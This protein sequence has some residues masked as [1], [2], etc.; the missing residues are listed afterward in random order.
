MTNSINLPTQVIADWRDRW[1]TNRDFIDG[2]DAV[3]GKGLRYLPKNRC[4]DSEA[5]YQAHKKRTFF[6]PGASKI[7]QGI[8]GLIFRNSAQ[9]SAKSARVELLSQL[10]TPQGQSKD[11]FAEW[12][13][14]ETLIT[15]F[16]GLLVDHPDASQFTGLTA[17][18]ADA[19]GFRPFIA[20]YAAENI[21]EVTPGIINEKVLPVYVLLLED[22]G[23]T[24]RELVIREDGIYEVRIHRE[25]SNGQY[26]ETT[27]YVPRVDGK[28]LTEIPFEIVNTRDKLVPTPSIL[29]YCVDLN[30]QHY[31]V[32]G[33]RAAM[34]HLTGAPIAVVKG[35]VPELD[36]DTGKPIPMEWDMSSGAV[37]M[38]SNKEAVVEWFTFD[39][40]GYALLLD[41][42]KDIKDT[43]STVGH[44]ILAPEKAAPE[45]PEYGLIRKAA[46]NATLAAFTRT[47]SRQLEK[48]FQ[49][50]AKWADPKNPDVTFTLNMDFQPA[51]M[52]AQEV[53]ALSGLVTA[54]QL[55]LETFHYALKDGEVV[56]PKFDP[57]EERA[58]L[59]REA[60][61]RPTVDLPLPG[62]P[63]AE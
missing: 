35:F 55:S 45:A 39:P 60:I 48:A 33:I 46:E 56:S 40:K 31:N 37:W 36:P 28:P 24:V 50:F 29:Q 62:D 19:L 4:D 13:V 25:V 32:E 58:R 38:I 61:D 14:R 52:S 7:E 22:E 34:L 16:T 42:L 30:R 11:G 59:D 8:S 2:E 18:N 20:G 49:R 12:V 9:F 17:A 21:L 27:R 1:T 23:K 41:F 63:E 51:Q 15:N 54:G 6:Y 47:V 44:S 57:V 10:M 5:E 53:T 3:K 26:V 43:M